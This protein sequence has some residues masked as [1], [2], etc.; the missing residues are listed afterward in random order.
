MVNV[1]LNCPLRWGREVGVSAELDMAQ[2]LFICK[3]NIVIMRIKLTNLCGFY[4][5]HWG[6]LF[7]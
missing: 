1:E 7:T 6:V 2:Q 3:Q 4:D 5:K